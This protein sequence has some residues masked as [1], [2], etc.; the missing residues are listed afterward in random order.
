MDRLTVDYCGEYV[1]KDMCSIDRLGGADDC[2]LCCEYCKATEEG[3]EDC[4]EC[5]IS[6]CFN[7]LGEYEDLEE[8]GKLL[9]LQTETVWFICDKNT[10]YAMVMSKSIRDLKVYE[11]EGIDME[12]Y[13]W[14]TKEAAEAA[15]KEMSE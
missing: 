15:L 9:K 11:I 12:G 6:K 5:A 2:D 8:Q 10:K 7:K 4:R 14:S 1:P 3:N 13:Y